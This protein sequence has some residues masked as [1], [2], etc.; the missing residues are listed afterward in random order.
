MA[1]LWLF[2]EGHGPVLGGLRG[3]WPGGCG[4]PDSM[5]H[6]DTVEEDE[7]LYDCVDNDEA[8][9]DEIYEDLMRTEP[10]PMPVRGDEGRGLGRC[11]RRRW[12]VQPQ[13]PQHW[14]LPST[15]SPR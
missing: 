3:T 2:R 5:S 10:V 11:T 13:A 12:G 9:G 4:G 8:E 6:S 1:L 7:D 15:L 14:P